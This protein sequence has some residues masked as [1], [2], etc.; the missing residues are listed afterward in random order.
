MLEII[1]DGQL[2]YWKRPKVVILELVA[3]AWAIDMQ[4]WEPLICRGTLTL[5]I[6]INVWSLNTFA[7][8]QKQRGFLNIE[9]FRCHSTN[10]LDQIYIFD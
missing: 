10:Q 3:E 9:I 8:M 7:W 2:N 6:G 5:S 1:Y 4:L